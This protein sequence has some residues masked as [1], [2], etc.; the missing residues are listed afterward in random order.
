[1]VGEN[2]EAL[3]RREMLRSVI[4]KKQISELINTKFETITPETALSDAV[5]K[6]RAADLYEIPVVEKKKLVGVLSF[7][8]MVKKRAMVAGMK[9]KGMMDIPP[10]ITA[11]TTI[12]EAAEQFIATNYRNMPV[13]KGSNLVGI[14][15]RADVIKIVQ[16]IKEFKD[17]KATDIMTYDITAVEMKEPIR[18]A[19]EMMRR[20]DV[21]TIPV[22]DDK[23]KLAGII[24]IRDIVNFSWSGGNKP[25]ET[26]G[27]KVGN[28]DPVEIQVESIMHPSVTTIKQETTVND[29]VKL[30]LEKNISTLPVV[31]KDVI[32]GVLTAYDV[33]ELMASVKE[34]DVVYMQI[35]GLEEEDRFNLDQMERE[36]QTELA[37]IA[38]I[39]KPMLFNMH[40]QKYN[41]SGNTAKYSLTAR[42]HTAQK[43][44][45]ASGVDWSLMAATADLMKRFDDMVTENK[46]SKIE[47][48]KKMQ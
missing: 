22:V 37:K 35:S 45:I 40:V 32:K 42:M 39:Q 1:M 11:E 30:M 19:L 48:R 5:A 16:G 24:G 20:I 25:K 14:L 2:L 17:M 6:M 18:N 7:G 3:K 38:K 34:R 46:E 26:R 8:S 29:A 33:L 15:S 13:V 31:E 27:E 12:T 4:D 23:F 43:T 21:R 44:Y 41:A 28:R 9:V 47:K 36:I 10:G